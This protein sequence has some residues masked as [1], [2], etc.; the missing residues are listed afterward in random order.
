MR[1]LL[2]NAVLLTMNRTFD[3][4]RGGMVLD[5]GRIEAL[6]AENELPPADRTIDIQGHVLLPG[7]VQSHVHT[8]QTL[9]RGAAD[10]LS[11]L[12][13]LRH[14]IWPLEAAHDPASLQAS[15]ELTV[16]ELL[17]GGTTAIL[18]METVRHTETVFET[19]ARLPVRAVVGKCMMDGGAH[20]PSSL[21]EDSERSL[22]ESL[23][24]ARAFPNRPGARLR[25]CLAPR[26]A[27]SCSEGLLRD[28]AAAAR[29]HDLLIHSH[30]AEQLQEVRLVQ[31]ATGQRN[32]AF[33][34][35]AGLSGA[36][37]RLAHV[38]HLDEAENE[39]LARSGTHVL[40]CPSSNLKLGSGT[41]PITR[42]LQRGVPVSI[43]ADGAPCNNSLDALREARLAALLQ[44][45][46]FGPTALPARTALELITRAGAAALGMAEEIGSLEAGKRADLVEID[47]DRPHVAPDGDVHARIVY[48]AERADIARVFFDG[49]VVFAGGRPAYCEAPALLERARRA[50]AALFAR[51]GL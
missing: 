29:E 16:L 28:V 33:L 18:S 36:R 9:F 42:Y 37:V 43:G 11:L 5:G 7:F 50:R 21:A 27:L 45:P 32:L 46:I 44:K 26:F 51:A 12:D 34:E 22:R 35:R 39:L 10:D 23:A 14:R 17:S 8:C 19:L 31:E 25:A 4:F 20:V 13:W 2:K 6:G 41:A 40:H 1:T 24:L 30:C 3:V 49:E 48:E 47:L 38:I 15:A